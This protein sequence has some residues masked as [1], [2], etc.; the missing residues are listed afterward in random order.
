MENEG[1]PPPEN[2]QGDINIQ[3][4]PLQENVNTEQ[5]N[6]Q[7]SPQNLSVEIKKE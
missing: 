4:P 7:A 6:E 1:N 3:Q 5:H 2:T